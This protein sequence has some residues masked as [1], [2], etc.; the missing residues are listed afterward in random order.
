MQLKN[1][2]TY[3]SSCERNIEFPSTPQPE[4]LCHSS[5]QMRVNSPALSG[6]ESRRTCHISRG[7]PSHIE[8]RQ[9]TSWAMPQS[10]RHRFPH[11]LEIRHDSNEIPSTQLQHEGALRSR[12]H[13]LEKAT[14]SKC[15][16]TRG[17][18]PHSQLKRQA[19]FH[20]STQDEACLPSSN[21]TETLRSN[22]KWRGILRFTPQLEMRPHSFL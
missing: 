5:S 11:P 2:P 18:T 6:K 20:A 3:L 22:Q 1:F 16:S 7:G 8:I 4:L 15:N 21:S 14:G 12:L 13:P 10:Q 9:E 17:L 19:E